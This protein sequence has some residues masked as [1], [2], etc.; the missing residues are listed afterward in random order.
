MEHHTPAEQLTAGLPI[1]ARLHSPDQH[2]FR[3]VQS[4]VLQAQRYKRITHAFKVAVALT[5]GQ[6]RLRQRLTQ[7]RQHLTQR[8]Q[9]LTQVLLSALRVQHCSLIT[10]VCKAALLT[11]AVRLIRLVGL[12]TLQVGLHTLQVDHL[13]QVQRSHHLQRIFLKAVPPVQSCRAMDLVPLWAMVDLQAIQPLII[14][15]SGSNLII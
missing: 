14:S 12:H 9:H 13:T 15:Q 2:Q 1:Q 7:R 11:Q 3:P 6:A 4:S 8:Q 10:H 5:S